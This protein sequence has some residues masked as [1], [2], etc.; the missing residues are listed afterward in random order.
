MIRH[1]LQREAC[2][3]VPIGKGRDVLLNDG[4]RAVKAD[5][6]ERCHEQAV[7][8][9]HASKGSNCLLGLVVEAGRLWLGPPNHSRPSVKEDKFAK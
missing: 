1:H 4:P 3:R 6:R 5:G 8:P 9:A 2:C 7:P